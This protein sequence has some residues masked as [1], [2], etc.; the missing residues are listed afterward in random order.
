MHKTSIKSIPKTNQKAKT[1][2]INKR[3][4]NDNH[5]RKLKVHQEVQNV[6][7]NKELRNALKI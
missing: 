4:V 3:K 1:P 5:L 6:D 7:I 2:K